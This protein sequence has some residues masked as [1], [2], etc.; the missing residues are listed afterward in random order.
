MKSVD[1]RASNAT[2][3]SRQCRSLLAEQFEAHLAATSQSHA[4]CAE[5]HRANMDGLL[6]WFG[7]IHVKGENHGYSTRELRSECVATDHRPT[8]RALP[9]YPGLTALRRHLG[10]VDPKAVDNLLAEL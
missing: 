8:Q 3:E 9:A 1:A 4:A 2:D 5:R 7:L 6:A 10:M